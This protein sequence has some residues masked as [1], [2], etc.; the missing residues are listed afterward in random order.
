MSDAVATRRPA[1]V[2][3]P[4]LE[5]RDLHVR[6]AVSG[7]RAQLRAVDGVSLQIAGGETFGLIGESGSGKSTVARAVTRLVRISS[8]TV[9]LAGARM[10]SMHG[11]VLRAARRRVQMVFQD[12]HESLDPRMSARQS[13][14]EPLRIAGGMSNAAIEQRVTELLER[15]ELHPSLGDRRPHQLSGGQKQRVNIA[16]ALAPGP[17]LLIC[18]EAVSALDLSVQAGVLN[19]LL[20]LQRELG[21][22]YLFI[23][24]DLGVVAHVADRIGVMYLGRLV[25]VAE[26]SAL[27]RR[28]RH[29]YTE[30]L[31]AAEPQ[32]VPSAYRTPRAA[33][34][35]GDIPSPL[36][37][38][39]GCHFRTR[40]AYAQAR[41]AAEEPLL[42][43][44]DGDWVACH[45]ADSLELRGKRT[46]PHTGDATGIPA[47]A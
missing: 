25:E 4:L 38:P 9:S 44:L 29:P 23:S 41:C 21:V 28:P 7:S 24:H 2:A 16:R 47:P 26:T 3:N 1:A 30:A 37:P 12:P 33:T 18:D 10:D 45:F 6:F 42:R 35:Q 14:G 20:E 15:V 8:G 13:V 39:S 27:V 17:E 19:L 34:L 36:D 31:L 32:A 11:R 22:A 5:V 46:R 43:E 40:C